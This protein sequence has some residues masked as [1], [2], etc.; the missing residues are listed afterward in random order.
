[1]TRLER[2]RGGCG[3]GIMGPEG[4]WES[5]PALLE[6]TLVPGEWMGEGRKKDTGRHLG[7]HYNARER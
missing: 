3:R 4:L 5:P 2:I 1:M 7:G 6:I